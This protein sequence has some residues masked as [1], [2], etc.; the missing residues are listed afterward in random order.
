MYNQTLIPVQ[1]KA[2]EY[3]LSFI[4]CS[5]IACFYTAQF[6]SAAVDNCSLKGKVVDNATGH[7]LAGAHVFLLESTLGTVTDESGLFHLSDL[8]SGEYKVGVSMLGYSPYTMVIKLNSEIEE[9]YEISLEPQVYELQH[10]T[11][12]GKRNRR[13]NKQLKQF[14]LQL[15]GDSDNASKTR[16][17]NPEVL[18]FIQRRDILIAEAQAPLIIENRALGYRIHYN[19]IHCII[20]HNLPQYKGIARFEELT[21]ANKREARKWEKNRK[22]AYEG[23]F[24]HLLRTLASKQDISEVEKAGFHL[25][26]VDKFPDSMQGYDAA[27]R[28]SKHGIDSFVSDAVL[29]EE[30]HLNID[31]HLLIL[32]THEYESDRYV[33]NQ[34][35]HNRQPDV[36][37]SSIQI[38]KTSP[39]FHENGF[40]YDA[41][42]V[43]LHGY[44]GWERM[45]EMLPMDYTP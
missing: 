41:Y 27:I 8:P 14:E 12:T 45:A 16:I 17:I 13:W 18:N 22:R 40:L 37:R 24:K 11:V 33:R 35:K 21:P 32:Y 5:C 30:R 20:Q 28:K 7:E 3:L 23:S 10:L 34:L 42:S 29:S 26:L 15:I 38:R 31:K 19:L 9:N 36:Q 43:V 4:V 39:V 2:V 6:A 25:A 44:M 1:R